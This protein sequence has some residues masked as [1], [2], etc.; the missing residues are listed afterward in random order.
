[1]YP[2]DLKYTKEHE[3]TRREEGAVRVGITEFAQ[4]AL[5]DIV[6]VD[7]PAAGTKVSAGQPLGEVE[8]TKSVSDIYS[9]VTGTIK[10]RNAALEDAPELVN[11]EPYGQGWMVLIELDRPDEVDALMSASDYQRIL[12]DTAL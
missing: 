3:W 4:E 7:L 9:P 5:G 8:S 12:D 2:E 10:E 11:Q 6:Y 1:M